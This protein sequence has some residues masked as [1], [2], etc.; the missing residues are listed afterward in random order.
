MNSRYDGQLTDDTSVR[1]Y[2]D[3]YRRSGIPLGPGD[4]AHISEAWD[5]VAHEPETYSARINTWYD[6]R[7]MM[8]QAAGGAVTFT[9]GPK[10]L[11][12]AYDR[13]MQVGLMHSGLVR[14]RQRDRT[15]ECEPGGVV[16]LLLSEPFESQTEGRTDITLLYVP[17]EYLESR[18]I[19]TQRL[20]CVTWEGGPLVAA[21]RE[22]VVQTLAM[23]DGESRRSA[24]YVERAL[25]ELIT[26]L[27]AAYDEG[28]ALADELAESTRQRVV[29]LVEERYA[30]TAV[31]P[32]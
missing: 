16:T 9:R 13:Y 22:L 15:V 6:E 29:D 31:G 27:F 2:R 17:V 24:P 4:L 14:S 8:T 5:I 20:S 7:L 1:S 11:R 30:D 26:G 18:G 23:D 12:D 25:L 3:R 32:E 28:F 10:H 21:F 19:N